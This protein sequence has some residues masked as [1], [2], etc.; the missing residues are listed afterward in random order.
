MT[1]YAIGAL[2][3]HD[4]G[5]QKEYGEAMP[6]LIDKHGGKVLAKAPAQTLEGEGRLPGT[7]VM[8][9][10]PT[11]AQARAWYDDPAHERLKQLRH[12]GADFDLLLVDG[13]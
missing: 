8:I 10:F 1:S 11:A 13:L 9:A 12:T 3:V 7:V 4:T 5:W 2:T 6:A